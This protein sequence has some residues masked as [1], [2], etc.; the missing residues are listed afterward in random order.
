MEL[1]SGVGCLALAPLMWGSWVFWLV[2][3]SALLALLPWV[4]P[5]AV[6]RRA[7]RRPQ[8]LIADP[9][10]R[11][12]RVRRFMLVAW[13]LYLVLA[14]A[15]GYLTSGVGGA[16]FAAVL[17]GAALAFAWRVVGRRS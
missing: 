3:G 4:G 15:M 8:I 11:R 13:P 1:L 10:R 2:L 9:E 12:R 6:L 5:A 16:A 17:M 7:E 14:A